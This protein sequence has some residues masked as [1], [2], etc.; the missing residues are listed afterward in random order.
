VPSSSRSSRSRR[1]R[2]AGQARADQHGRARDRGASP[3]LLVLAIDHPE[4]F[5]ARELI[6]STA[7]CTKASSKT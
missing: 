1:R 3:F 5:L 6:G 2:A 4:R 7:A